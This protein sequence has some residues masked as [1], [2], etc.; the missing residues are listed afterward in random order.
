MTPE[1]YRLVRFEIASLLPA[2]AARIL[3]VGCGVGATSAWLKRKYPGCHTIGLERNAALLDELSDNVDEPLILDLNGDLP[4]A[5]PV[6]LVLMLDVL[7]HLN[8]PEAVLRHIVTMMGEDATAIISLPNVAHL[9][10][11]LRLLLLGRFDYTDAGI[12]DRTHIRFFY[13]GSALELA[14]RAGLRVERGLMV[15]P[16]GPK[17]RWIDRLSFGLIRDRLTKQ[18]IF[19]ARRGSGRSAVDWRPA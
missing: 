2:A 6:D 3:D 12:L 19:A 8:E 5:A 14:G 7:E 13:K 18:Y 9:S 15:G 17:S 16:R 11:A 10:V 1:Y 4:E